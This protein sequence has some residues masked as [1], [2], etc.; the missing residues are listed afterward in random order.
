LL[1]RS[2]R[3]G[4]SGGTDWAGEGQGLL[5]EERRR[6]VEEQAELRQCIDEMRDRMET[7]QS[8]SHGESA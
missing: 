8:V 5:E 3:T 7:L 6:A 1:G 4:F 2:C